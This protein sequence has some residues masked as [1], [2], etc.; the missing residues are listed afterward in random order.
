M[1]EMK[2]SPCGGTRYEVALP[3]GAPSAYTFS[4]WICAVLLPG[5][6][7]DSEIGRNMSKSPSGVVGVGSSMI[8]LPPGGVTAPPPPGSPE[9]PAVGA[10]AS[11]KVTFWWDCWRTKISAVRLR[12]C[13]ACDAG[14]DCTDVPIRKMLARSSSFEV[15]MFGCLYTLPWNRRFQPWEVQL[16]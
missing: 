15:E 13:E 10:G 9:E 6:R 1:S 12:A 7:P 5:A 11:E 3:V 14:S 8:W 2:V 4:R 16:P